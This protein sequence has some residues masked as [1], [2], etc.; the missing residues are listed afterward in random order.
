ME[1]EN[2]KKRERTRFWLRIKMIV[3]SG[4]QSKSREGM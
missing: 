3:E 4:L 2:K 1:N